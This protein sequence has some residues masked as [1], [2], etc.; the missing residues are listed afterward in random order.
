MTYAL[1]IASPKIPVGSWVLITGVNGLIA[2]HIADQLLQ[3]GYNV[4]GTV[5]NPD[6]N[7]WMTDYFAQ[8]Y[9]KAKFELVQ[10][11]DFALPGA[12]YEAVKGV[13]G[14]VHTT[15]AVHLSSTSPDPTI[16]DRITTVLSV[17]SSAL[18]EPSIKSIVVTSSA[19][20]AASPAPDVE[21][22]ITEDTWNEQA[23]ADA[24]AV[25]TPRSHGM[26][27]FMAAMAESEQRVWQWVKEETPQFTVNAVLPD[28][29]FG[30][31]LEPSQQG[32]PSTAGFVKMMFDSQGLDFLKLIQPQWFCDV[33]DTA[34]LHVAA[35]LVPDLESQRIFAY[36]GQWNWNDVLAI[37]RKIYPDREFIADLPLGK[38]LSKVPP[39]EKSLALLRTAYGQT[40]WTGLEVSIKANVA[41]FG[42]GKAT[43]GGAV[44]ESLTGR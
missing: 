31:I 40:E 38:D 5:R 12:F 35:L 20:A 4:R 28:T 15:A 1:S 34:R 18:K 41:S 27:I 2:S 29:V 14:V 7:A 6:K 10:V 13:A 30:A 42:N 33:L 44:V 32:A 37:F 8:K 17:F 9:D 43:A 25:G 26:S 39:R 22:T 24:W 19:W 21:F 11:A 3:A 16:K 23:V 36:G